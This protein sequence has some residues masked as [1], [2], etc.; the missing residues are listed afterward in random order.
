MRRRV[1]LALL[2]LA[3]TALIAGCIPPSN[4]GKPIQTLF[5]P[6]PSGQP[7]RLLVILPGRGDDLEG[8]RRSGAA[9]AAQRAWPDADVVYAELTLGYYME[10]RAPERLHAEVIQPARERGRYRQVWLAG[11]SMGGMGVILYDRAH[12]GALDGLVLMAPY[13]G[14]GKIVR[15]V[16]DAGGVATWNAGPPQDLGADTFQREMWRHIQ[17]WQRTPAE[18]QRVWLTYGRSDRLR[19][20]MP[21]LAPALDPD[22]VRVVDGGHA[23]KVWSPALEGV[24]RAADADR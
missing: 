23:W 22:P 16:A 12:P 3:A 1:L 18:G 6:A 20:A 24:L 2:V 19:R 10:G 11:A 17:R 21:V 4:P 15:E 9:E 14:D 13:L 8:L 7:Q 5:V